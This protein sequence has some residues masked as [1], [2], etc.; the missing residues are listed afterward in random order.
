MEGNQPRPPTI[1][2][3]TKN[4]IE[5]I[6]KQ[7]QSR[8]AP[9]LAGQLPGPRAQNPGAGQTAAITNNMPEQSGA[10]AVNLSDSGEH[11]HK[12]QGSRT[13]I[14][15]Q[16]L[17]NNAQSNPP[18]HRTSQAAQVTLPQPPIVRYTYKVK[19]I[20]PSKKSASIVRY[21]HNV[22]SKFESVNGL[23]VRLMDE[24][25]DQ[26]PKTATFD[27]G[28]F[29]GKQ[30]SKIWLVTS[31]DLEKLYDVY[32]KGGEVHLWCDGVCE[33]GVESCRSTKRSKEAESAG[34]KRSQQEGEVESIYK[35]LKEK[36]QDSWDTPRLQLWARC[37][38]SGIHDDYDIP[39][40]SPAF[41]TA[42]PK[43]ARKESLSEAIGGAAVAIV[44]ALKSD[45]NEK[46]GDNSQ[47]SGAVCP[48]TQSGPG[49]SPG[50]A[51]D[52]IFSN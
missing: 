16:V 39:P 43:R 11:S 50:R 44:K 5:Q 29:E 15:V 17:N 18:R 23:R 14:S 38:V 20:N 8:A 24:F 48:G 36:H 42:A 3:L 21:L 49:V 35:E 22:S 7:Q 1:V 52:L 2:P 33:T 13:A 6:F 19:I 10:T 31:K 34:T 30:Q 46:T 40:D 47:S 45:P 26:V 9:F 51:V 41:S 28:Y 27:V 4:L 32:P 37:I 25:Q 12:G